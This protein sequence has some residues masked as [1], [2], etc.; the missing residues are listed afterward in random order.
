MS[1]VQVLVTTTQLLAKVTSGQKRKQI[2][3]S[4]RG[5]NTVWIIAGTPAVDEEG[6]P[7]D[8]GVSFGLSE[9]LTED[10]LNQQINAI[11]PDGTTGVSVYAL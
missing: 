10:K 1:V 3:V 5:A 11:A 6:I 9:I 2:I 8:S 4:N 7:L